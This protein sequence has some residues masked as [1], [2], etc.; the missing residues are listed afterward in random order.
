M[1]SARDLQ[2]RMRRAAAP[3]AEQPTIVECV[4]LLECAR[5]RR[6]EEHE[7]IA[8]AGL[9]A[10]VPGRLHNLLLSVCQVIPVSLS[11][12]SGAQNTVQGDYLKA[13]LP[14]GP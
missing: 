1:E 8:R 9:S 4:E 5:R 3:A 6:F 10:R 14:N 7:R 13:V 2:G 12:R 11:H